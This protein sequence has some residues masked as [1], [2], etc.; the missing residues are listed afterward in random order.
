MEPLFKHPEMPR[1]TA[2]PFPPYRYLPFVEGMPHPRR[3]PAGH[4]YGK[5][6]E[7]LP[8]FAAADWRDCQLYL[9]GIDLFNSGYWWEAHEALETVWL[10]AGRE[11][12][13]GRFVQ[14]LIQ[15][16]VAQLKRFAGEPRG[17]QL[18][19]ETGLVRLRVAEPVYLG[20]EVAPLIAEVQRCLAEDAGEYPQIRLII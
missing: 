9:Y 11:S 13:A 7:Y 5:E 20:I 12:V 6:E 10:A 18:L 8:G 4:S 3:D 14:G 17:A 19:T 16:A 15:L 2:E 1:H